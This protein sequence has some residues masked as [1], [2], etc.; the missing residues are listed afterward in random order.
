MKKLLATLIASTFPVMAS[1]VTLDIV[2]EIDTGAN[3]ITN[4]IQYTPSQTADIQ[5]A[6]DNLQAGGTEVQ[7]L[8]KQLMKRVSELVF[9]YQRDAERRASKTAYSDAVQALVP[10]PT[11]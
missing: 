6:V 3:V 5:A 4:R 7:K 11:E 8:R 2:L 9:E 10:L 1:A